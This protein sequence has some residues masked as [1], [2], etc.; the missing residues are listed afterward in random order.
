MYIIQTLYGD[1]FDLTKDRYDPEDFGMAAVVLSHICRFGG[2]CGWHYS[3]AQHSVLVCQHAPEE[4]KLPALLHDV[5]EVITGDIS[6]PIKELLGGR[7]ELSLQALEDRI[8][9]SAAQ[10]HGFDPLLF[11][12]VEAIDMQARATE[13]RDLMCDSDVDWGELPEPWPEEICPWV[14]D[15]AA[16][17][18][19]ELYLKWS[20]Q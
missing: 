16:F 11:R 14:A 10:A 4:L 8:L 5:G 9:R 18:W 7:G 2:H 17:K 12:E 20:N 19:N 1:S 15:F 6:A 13:R 3:V